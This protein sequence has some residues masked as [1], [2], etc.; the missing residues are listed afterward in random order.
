MELVAVLAYR[1]YRNMFENVTLVIL[2]LE[3]ANIFIIFSRYVSLC[4][5]LP[6]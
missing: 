1:T 4:L 2:A 5:N 6:L 3:G